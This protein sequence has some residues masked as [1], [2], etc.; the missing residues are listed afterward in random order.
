M[1]VV[2]VPSVVTVPTQEPS[3]S[4]ASSRGAQAAN[5]NTATEAATASRTLMRR[6][7][8]RLAEPFNGVD[9]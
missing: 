3:L 5:E 2:T 4:A 1:A 6:R 9:P 7:L 8:K